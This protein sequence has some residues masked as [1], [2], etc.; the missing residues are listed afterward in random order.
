MNETT[1]R[2]AGMDFIQGRR[3]EVGDIFPDS[4]DDYIEEGSK[5]RVIDAL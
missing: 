5:A 1:M 3:Q 4:I 2:G